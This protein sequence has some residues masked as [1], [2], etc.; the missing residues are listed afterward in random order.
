MFK[1]IEI[2]IETEINIKG[3]EI[4][5]MTVERGKEIENKIDI[6]IEMKKMIEREGIN[7]ETN[8]DQGIEKIGKKIRRI[9]KRRERDLTVIKRNIKKTLTT[10]YIKFV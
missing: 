6:D 2:K 9:E 3:K 10:D 1:E 7:I 5:I 4:E 8:Q